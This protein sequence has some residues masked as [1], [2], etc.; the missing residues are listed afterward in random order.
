MTIQR[1]GAA[2]PTDDLATTVAL[3]SAVFGAEPTVVDGDRWA[4]FDAGGVRVML[5][6][7]D[8]DDDT[9][10]LAIKVDDL[11]QTLKGLRAKGFEVGPPITGPH[12]GR[13]VLRPTPGSRWH[14]A[15]YEPIEV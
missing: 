4:Q 11:D 13:A 14:I 2:Y 15:I 9:P 7:T 10:F 1:I 12:E 6:G 5:A 3:L 8:R